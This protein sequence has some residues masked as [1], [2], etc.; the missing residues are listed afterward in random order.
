MSQFKSINKT[1]YTGE[2]TTLIM[3]PA[4]VFLRFDVGQGFFIP[5][6]GVGYTFM[7]FREESPDY[8][9][10]TEGSGGN[11]ALEAGL[12]LKFNR[13]VYLD[14][15]ARFDKIKFK[16]DNPALAEVDLGGAQ[17]GVSLLISF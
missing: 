4:N 15:G 6:A 11:F 8:L 7:S 3:L 5:Y 12:E 14:L 17:A 16:P 10:N 1:T 13:H 9:G 2:K